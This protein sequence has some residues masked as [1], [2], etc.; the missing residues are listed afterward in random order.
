MEQQW[1]EVKNYHRETL[2]LAVNIANQ[3]EKEHRQQIALSEE[4][5]RLRIQKH[6]DEIQ[7]EAE[8]INFDD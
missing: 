1:K 2:K 3:T 5:E 6:K 8:Q 4:R 7:K